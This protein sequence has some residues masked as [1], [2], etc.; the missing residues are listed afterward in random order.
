MKRYQLTLC[1]GEPEEQ[2]VYA[3]L[4]EKDV[5]MIHKDMH[6]ELNCAYYI[7]LDDYC[8]IDVGIIDW[9]EELK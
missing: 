6:G 8:I 7:T 3:T 9:I 4:T 2:V 5:E 1:E